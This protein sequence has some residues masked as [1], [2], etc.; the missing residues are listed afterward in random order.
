MITHYL[1]IK[2][3]YFG[4]GEVVSVAISDLYMNRR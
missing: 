2:H 3:T 4:E 1:K